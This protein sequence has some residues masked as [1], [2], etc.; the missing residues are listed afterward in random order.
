MSKLPVISGVKV[1]RALSKIGYEVFG[2]DASQSGVEIA[3]RQY[4][5]SV[6]FVCSEIAPALLEKL[7]KENFDLVVS[8]DVIEHL[9]RPSELIQTARG[10]L[11]RGGY[12]LLTTPY[13]GYFKYLALSLTGQMDRHLN[14]LYDGGHIKFFSVQTL[15]CLIS[16]YGFRKSR[17]EF[18]GRLPWLWKSTI[19]LARKI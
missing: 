8:I 3:K 6:K 4:G 11:R 16:E 2:V 5:P 7:G 15:S 13:H 1:V 9:Y 10:L 14:P 17:F 12:F 18:F 19:C